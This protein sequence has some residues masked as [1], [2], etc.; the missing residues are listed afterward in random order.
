MYND[1]AYNRPARSQNER[2]G[3]CFSERLS[4][5]KPIIGQSEIKR[6]KYIASHVWV[7]MQ[8]PKRSAAVW[9]R[10]PKKNLIRHSAWAYDSIP[11]E[12]PKSYTFY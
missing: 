1:L 5:K 7:Y 8:V 2:Y 6:G 12:H 11:A 3:W 4:I 10:I 9:V